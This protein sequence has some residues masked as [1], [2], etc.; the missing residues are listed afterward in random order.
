MAEPT[1][2]PLYEALVLEITDAFPDCTNA[3][4][5]AR[6]IKNAHTMLM[7][8]PEVQVGGRSIAGYKWDW[9]SPLDTLNTIVED[10]TGTASVINGDKTVTAGVGLLIWPT[11]SAGATIVIT[12]ALGVDHSFT[13]DSIG[14]PITIELTE[15]WDGLTAFNLD[16]EIHYHPD[17]YDLPDDFGGLVGNRISIISVA[18]PTNYLQPVLV[19][20]LDEVL[21]YYLQDWNPGTPRYA[22]I[23]PVPLVVAT[24]QRWQIGLWPPPDGEYSLGFRYNVNLDAI[25]A[26]EYSAGGPLVAMALKK[27]CLA[28]AE[29]LV[30]GGAPGVY[31]GQAM[32]AL[33]G[34]IAHDMANRPRNLG[35]NGDASDVNAVLWNINGTLSVNGVDIGV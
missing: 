8:P 26:A 27:C 10:D 14:I 5:L 13:V 33:A 12:D 34:A 16:Y 7:H 17:V 1:T 35:Y 22:V 6:I 23:M 3:A 29:L 19:R 4:R 18:S 25:T 28:Q 30:S 32:Q 11:W 21:P 15:A 24:G 2:S 9:L 31:Y 20:T